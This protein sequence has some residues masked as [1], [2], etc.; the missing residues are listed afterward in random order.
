MLVFGAKNR[1]ITTVTFPEKSAGAF[2]R[3]QALAVDSTGRLYIF[4]ERSQRI[5]VYQ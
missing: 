3:P 4:D 2:S 5:Q 1:L